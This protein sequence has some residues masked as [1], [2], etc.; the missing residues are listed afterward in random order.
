MERHPGFLSPAARSPPRGRPAIDNRIIVAAILFLLKTGI[1]WGDLPR[2]MGCS[3]K[4]C[5]RRLKEW[6]TAR[7]GQRVYLHLLRG[8]RLA[9]RL[10][11]AEVLVDAGLVKVPFGG[12]RPAQ[13]QRTVGVAAARCI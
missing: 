9:E 12:C 3:Y 4:T 11:L 13:T 8:L 2:E 5:L 10:E 1:A 6:T 7:V